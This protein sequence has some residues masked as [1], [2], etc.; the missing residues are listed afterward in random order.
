MASDDAQLL[1]LLEEAGLGNTGLTEEDLRNELA[2]YGIELPP[3]EGADYFQPIRTFFG[4]AGNV[5]GQLAGLAAPEAYEAASENVASML[6]VTPDSPW[7]EHVEAAPGAG[8][9][10]A[11]LVP[12]SVSESL[13]GKA[14]GPIGRMA[15]NILGDPTTYVGGFLAKGAGKIAATV[16]LADDA[17]RAAQ[18]ASKE[19]QMGVAAGHLTAAAAKMAEAVDAERIAQIVMREGSPLQRN[20][21]TLS[22]GLSRGGDLAMGTG[23]ALAYGPEVVKA[24]YESAK[25]IPEAESFGEGAAQAVNTALMG[26]LSALM[27]KGLI[28]A[29]EAMATLRASSTGKALDAVRGAVDEGQQALGGIVSELPTTR[30]LRELGWADDQISQMNPDDASR[31]MADDLTPDTLGRQAD[32]LPPENVEVAG[33]PTDTLPPEGPDP[34]T[35]PPRAGVDTLAEPPERRFAHGGEPL[36]DQAGNVV[37]RRMPDG[38]VVPEG[39]VSDMPPRRTMESAPDAGGTLPPVRDTGTLPP[40]PVRDTGTLP[41]SEP[42]IAPVQAEPAVSP[43][44]TDLVP[45]AEFVEGGDLAGALVK[46][47]ATLDDFRALGHQERMEVL[48]GKRTVEAPVSPVEPKAGTEPV[49]VE[50]EPVLVAPEPTKAP[51]AEPTAQPADSTPVVSKETTQDITPLAPDAER[52]RLEGVAAEAVTKHADGLTENTTFKGVVR[53]IIAGSEK[54]KTGPDSVRAGELL[55][56]LDDV[57][58][59]A[60]LA[61]A[62]DG[63]EA[64]N[65]M[66]TVK[67]FLDKRLTKGGEGVGDVLPTRG[68]TGNKGDVEKAGPAKGTKADQ[69]KGATDTKLSAADKEPYNVT[70]GIL[71]AQGLDIRQFVDEISDDFEVQIGRQPTKWAKN[72]ELFKEFVELR[73]GGMSQVDAINELAV[74]HKAR[75]SGAHARQS[76]RN[77]INAHKKG[78]LEQAE[79]QFKEKLA[80]NLDE[81]PTASK[82]SAVDVAGLATAH[83]QLASQFPV[84]ADGVPVADFVTAMKTNPK[85]VLG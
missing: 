8:D 56:V 85:A 17:I 18:I 42:T 63:V 39:R 28:D 61:K 75:F 22:E 79:A 30:R 3:P 31:I 12:E 53:N 1:Q 50:P 37:A 60:D 40:E 64:R 69:M 48:A 51:P 6:G 35:M 55:T 71:K 54:R 36:F 25:A 73:E 84:R 5:G 4:G 82:P 2:S 10:L 20:A 74:R 13:V 16:P 27:G 68:A 58:A 38:A 34:R 47:G 80:E 59:R 26:G 45:Y 83:K 44:P 78:V 62:L 46:Q 43:L 65:V 66:P 41:P 67:G 11:E 9:V 49:P 57:A 77:L 7:Y 81:S 33:P 15:G 70:K 23:A 14:L 32:T 76:I 19:R 24:T 52:V 29:G 21:F 72:K